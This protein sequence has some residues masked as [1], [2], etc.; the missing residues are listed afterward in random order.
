MSARK[1]WPYARARQ[2]VGPDRIVG[3]TC[4][5]SRHRALVASEAGADY[6]AFGAFFP[7]TTKVAKHHPSPEVLKDWSDMTRSCRAA[8]SAGSPRRI[9]TP[10]SK[11]APISSR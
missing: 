7:S 10:W 9:A 3:V 8:R 4:G 11:P 6:V 5:A 2:A 1:T